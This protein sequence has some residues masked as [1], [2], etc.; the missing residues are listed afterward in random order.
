MHIGKVNIGLELS[1]I[2]WW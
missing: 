2:W 1:R